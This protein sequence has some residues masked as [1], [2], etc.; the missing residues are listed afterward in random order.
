MNDNLIDNFID[1]LID[2][3]IDCLIDNLIVYRI[4]RPY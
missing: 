4:V 1:D 3:H 2:N